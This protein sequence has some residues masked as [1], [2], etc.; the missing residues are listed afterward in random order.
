MLLDSTT[1]RLTHRLAAEQSGRRLPSVAA[2]LVRRDERVWSGAVGTV[3]GLADGTPATT[4]TQYRIGSITKTFTAVLVMRLRDEGRLDLD[5]P[6]ERHVPDAGVTATVAQLLSHSS[7]L[8]AET[9]GSW[10]ERSPGRTWDELAGHLAQRHRPG[11][12]HH[13]S[14]TGYA[15]LGRLVEGHRGACWADA[16]R[17]ELLE[18]LGMG[19]TTYLPAGPAATGLGVHPFADLVIAEAVQDTRA[20]APAGQLWS[21]ADDLA[22]WARF[23]GGDTGEVLRRG[24]WEEMCRPMAWY[25]VPGEPWTVAHGLGIQVWNRDGRRLVGHGGSMPGFL[26]NVLVDPESGDGVVT[27]ANA[28]TGLTGD[29]GSDLL[30]LLGD[31]EPAVRGPWHAQ[32][33]DDDVRELLGL[34]HW[35]TAP[36][37]LRAGDDGR[38]ELRPLGTSGRGSRFRRISSNGNGA[39]WVGLDGYFAGEPLEVRRTGDGTAYLDLASFR[40]TRTPYQTDADVPGGVDPD[41]WRP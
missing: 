40:F 12:R 24:T 2:A 19:R 39:G 32:P 16:V 11:H 35:G 8:Q 18:P 29:L 10:W 37:E 31:A 36:H 9:D 7:G 22:R 26:A 6:V 41:G 14:N 5:D 17:E 33:A 4:D 1:V 25:D 20:M 3:D 23:L 30:R 21:T 28:T 27:M 34:W 13:Y 15:V 38:L